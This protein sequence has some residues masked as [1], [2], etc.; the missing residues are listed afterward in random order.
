MIDPTEAFFAQ[1]AKRGE[2]PGKMM[3]EM[4]FGEMATFSLILPSPQCSANSNC[5]TSQVVGVA[6]MPLVVGE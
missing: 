5:S 3:H 2:E 1:L 4:R 6:S